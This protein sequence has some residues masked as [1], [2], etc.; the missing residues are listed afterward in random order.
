[1]TTVPLYD[2][3]FGLLD[4]GT[5]LTSVSLSKKSFL[6]GWKTRSVQDRVFVLYCAEEMKEA[7]L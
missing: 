1:M 2:Y 6:T 3:A 4:F 5:P 7:I